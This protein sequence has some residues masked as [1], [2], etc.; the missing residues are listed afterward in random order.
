MRTVTREYTL[1]PIH[2]LSG[3]AQQTAYYKWLEQVEYTFSSD[4]SSTMDEFSKLF[5]LNIRNWSYDAYSYNYSFCTYL[6]GEVEELSGERL[7]RYIHN[8]HWFKIFTPKIYWGAMKVGGKT[9]KRLS[10]I[11]YTSDCPLTGYCADCAILKP[12]YD[13]LTH[14][15]SKI[16]YLKLMERCLES[17][18]QFCRD[19]VSYTQSEESFKEMS[20]ANDWEYLSNG[21]LFN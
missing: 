19:D 21:K 4:N 8:N 6:S 3:E 12:I 18:F 5:D 2:E 20:Q 15:D 11:F 14:P 9:T 17:F 16:T 13:F 1:F 7:A 10:R